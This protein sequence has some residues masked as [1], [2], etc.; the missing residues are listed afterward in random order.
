V[1]EGERVWFMDSEFAGKMYYHGT[2]ATSDGAFGYGI[3]ATNFKPTANPNK[4]LSIDVG[5]VVE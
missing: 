1:E 5:F 2:P 3:T 4:N